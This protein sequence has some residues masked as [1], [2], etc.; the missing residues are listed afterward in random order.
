MRWVVGVGVVGG[1]HPGKKKRT[2][3]VQACVFAVISLGPGRG[4]EG[5]RELCHAGGVAEGGDWNATAEFQTLCPDG[6]I[7]DSSEAA[8]RNSASSLRQ[9]IKTQK[10]RKV[11]KP[12]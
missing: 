2:V 12:K 1:E 4:M 5:G 7:T 10:T 8:L 3:Q 6:I 11:K 9:H